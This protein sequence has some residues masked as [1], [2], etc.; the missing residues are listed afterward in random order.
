M[1]TQQLVS[2]LLALPLSQRIDVAA[3]LWDSISDAP[4]ADIANE[5]RIVI[6]TAKKRRTELVD[7]LVVGR[8]H[9]DVMASAGRAIG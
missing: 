1:S 8:S 3:T 7:G 9:D 6:E 4:D 2:E 5:E